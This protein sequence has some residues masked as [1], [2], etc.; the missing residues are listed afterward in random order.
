MVTAIEVYK[1]VLAELKHYNTTSMTPDEFNYHIWIA[2][3]EYVKNRYWAH[4]QHQKQ[5][6]DLSVIKVVTDG[7]AGFPVPLVNEG[8][9]LTGKEYITLPTNYLHL[10]AVSVRVKYKNVPCET[11][12][13][14]SDYTAATHLKDDKRFV[15]HDDYYQKPSAEWPNLYYDQ[16]GNKLTFQCGVSVVQDVMISY[17][18]LPVRITFDITGQNNVASEFE[19]PQ[20]LEIVKHC[21]ISYLETIKDQR[22]QSMLPINE[23]NFLQTPPPN[24]P[25]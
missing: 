13:T 22:V 8:P 14:L 9:A 3:L 19:W 16:R 25:T 23:R 12:G 11:D 18:R 24:V 4:E 21:V 7:V 15:V 6:D 10:L 2:E 20:T 1:A 5:I 17:L